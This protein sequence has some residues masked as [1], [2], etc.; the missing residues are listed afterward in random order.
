MEEHMAELKEEINIHR[1]KKTMGNRDVES[2]KKEN[3]SLTNKLIQLQN[4]N[5][6]L[7]HDL[8]EK[9]RMLLFAN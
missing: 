2:V 9:T 4:E 8:S 3:E 6:E 5:E 1:G 7:K